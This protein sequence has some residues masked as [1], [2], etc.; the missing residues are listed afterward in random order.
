MIEE[1]I[2]MYKDDIGRLYM[3]HEDVACCM[4]P[5]TLND[6]TT[7]WY[8]SLP[9]GSITSW[10]QLEQSFLNQF[11]MPIDPIQSTYHN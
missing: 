7:I 4:F 11:S 10:I 3:V 1:H 2:H 8:A 6:V 5:N 9:E